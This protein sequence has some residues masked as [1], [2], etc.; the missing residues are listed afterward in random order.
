MTLPAI[1]IESWGMVRMQSTNQKNDMRLT[2]KDW[3]RL[4]ETARHAIKYGLTYKQFPVME[5]KKYSERLQELG[6]SFVTLKESNVLRGCIGSLMAHQPLI[7]DVAEH[8][9][10]A[11]FK[12]PRFPPINHIEE[13]VIHISVSV[14]SLPEELK[15]DSE[16]S[17]LSQIQS[18]HDGLILEFQ[19]KKGT[20]LPSVW[21]Q[22]PKKK[23]FL[24]RLK[25]KTGLA[26]TF[27]SNEIKVSRYYAQTID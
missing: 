14:L 15:F 23:D 19:N 9:F 6:A 4:L 26:E 13:P 12:D 25:E 24:N 2:P 17:L 21:E 11:A 8:A 16:E 7:Q 1:K 3:S 18:N 20:F 5:L 27:W 22:L 10:S